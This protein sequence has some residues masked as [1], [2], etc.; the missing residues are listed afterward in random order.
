MG[1]HLIA[2]NCNYPRNRALS[3]PGKNLKVEK[4]L[5]K[6]EL[7]DVL[8]ISMRTLNY[9]MSTDRLPQPLRLGRIVRW[10]QPQI[11]A[12]IKIQTG[13]SI[14]QDAVNLLPRKHGRPRGQGKALL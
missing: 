13:Q 6:R 2:H 4:L 7:A 9:W 3:L 5:N 1:L 14:N 12:W 8:G 10:S 11:D